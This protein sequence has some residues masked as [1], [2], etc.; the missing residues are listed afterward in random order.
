MKK[1]VKQSIF[2]LLYISC[3]LVSTPQ[4]T[5]AKEETSGI[6]YSYKIIK[7]QNQIGNAGYFDLRMSPEQNQTVEIELYN[8]TE[9]EISIDLTVNSAK[10]N[11][12][13]VV[14]YGPTKIET[15]KSLKYDL[16]DIAKVP[17]K[18]TIP[19]KT[20][21][22]VPVEITMPNEK[23][24]GYISGG[25]YLQKSE[26]ET[27]K[28]ANESTQG[29]VNKY[30]FIV[31]MLLSESDVKVKPELTFNKIY[32]GLTNYRNAFLVNFSNTEATYI[33][34]MTI[35]A[36]ILKK[37]SDEVSYE[38]KK[39]NYRMAPNSSMTFPINLNGES[40]A[41]GDY[42]GRILVTAGDRK[43][44]WEENF[45]VTQKEAEKYNAE[46]VT[47]IQDRGINWQL[48]LMIAGGILLILIVS[49]L[50]IRYLSN[51]NKKNR[52]KQKR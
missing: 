43:W 16:K 5:Y 9:E 12:N 8:M 24:D 6:G 4:T 40:F 23:Y 47:L 13:G 49:Y 20:T 29:V 3:L 11:S 31:G 1:Y 46:D 41:A 35:D 22:K 27:E 52:K 39:E 17:E 7:P 42:V 45:K 28:K 50:L 36:Q 34:G 15:D 25:I 38:A 14:E 21:Q 32:A 51:R 48:L 33:E 18:V 2:F 44:E 19:P 26:T 10:T 30:A 37:G